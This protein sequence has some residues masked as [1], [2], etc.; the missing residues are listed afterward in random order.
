MPMLHK[1]LPLIGTMQLYFAAK[2]KLKMLKEA[3][4]EARLTRGETIASF[5]DPRKNPSFAT[6]I[7]QFVELRKQMDYLLIEAE[8]LVETPETAFDESDITVS[9]KSSPPKG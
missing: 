7:T 5:Y 4:E 2:Y 1:T 8:K 3:L 6:Q 9:V